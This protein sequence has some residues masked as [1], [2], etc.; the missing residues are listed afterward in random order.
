M[1][2]GQPLSPGHQALQFCGRAVL[3]DSTGPGVGAVEFLCLT[4]RCRNFSGKCGFDELA[5]N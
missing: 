5:G 2:G 4:R 3:F 1:T